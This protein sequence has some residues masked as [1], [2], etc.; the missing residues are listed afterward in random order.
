MLTDKDLEYLRLCVDLATRA[1]ET[2]NAPFGSL[3]VGPEGEILA[4]DHNQISSG[5]ETHHPEL[6][7]TQW[8]SRNLDPAQRA[9]ST[10][11]TSGEHCAMCSAAHGW[12]G[13]GRIV[14]AT[15][16]AQ[17]VGWMQQWGIEPFPVKPLAI[18]DV[19]PNARVDG[20]APTLADEVRELQR[21]YFGL[22]S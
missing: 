13:L 16:S 19:L 21:R 10:V 9:A 6:T 5:D 7:I 18:N 15:S 22:D 8:A 11:Y 12:V 17:L 14:Y 1:L 3:L 20:P 2:G 4:Q